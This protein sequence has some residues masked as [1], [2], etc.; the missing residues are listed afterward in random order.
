MSLSGTSNYISVGVPSIGL[1]TCGAM[2]SLIGDQR[3]SRKD[4]MVRQW[5]TNLGSMQHHSIPVVN[6]KINFNFTLHLYNK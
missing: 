4:V 6:T 3:R 1:S 2:T 5:C